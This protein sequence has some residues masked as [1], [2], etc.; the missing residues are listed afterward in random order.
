MLRGASLAHADVGAGRAAVPAADRVWTPVTD[1]PPL[2]VAASAGYGVTESQAGEG[3]HHRVEGTLAAAVGLTPNI[4]ASLGFEGRYDI[5][6]DGDSG[7][8]GTPQLGLVGGV[9]AADS[10]RIG[11]ALQL[12]VPG[13]SAPS[14]D[15]SALA[16][17]MCGLAAWDAGQHFT[18]AGL[19]GF[20]FDKSANAAADAERLSNADRLALGLSDFNAVPFGLAAFQRVA[21]I[22]LLAELSGE[23]LVGADAPDVLHSPL[24]AALGGRMPIL[25][26]LMAELLLELSLSQRSEYARIAPLIPQEPRFTIGLGLRYA[27]DFGAAKPPPPA[28]VVAPERTR[29]SGEISDPD[30][31][32]LAGVRVTVRVAGR[33][34]SVSSEDDGS[35]V[36]EDLP[37]GTAQIGI[38]GAGLLPS[39]Q[40]VALDRREVVLPLQVA[41]AAV[42]AQ[43]RGLVRSFTGAALP[44]RVRVLP[45][46]GAVTADKDGRFML[47]LQA[48]EYEVE[49]ECAGYLTQ[50]RKIS[51]QDNGVTLLNVELHE[52]PR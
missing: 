15:F 29:L 11:A 20:R 37:R 36:L 12:V 16:L 34:Y 49:I 51:V 25:P 18:L 9:H 14:L 1:A 10:V 42:S 35:F 38:E 13:R 33:E 5:H 21:S 50:H 22:E 24:R 28:P 17:S 7:A 41:R 26:T 3:A 46:A 48:G 6:P 40:P 27:P 45:D 44:A 47:E 30:G 2:S 31:V 32:R 4:A 43:L 52:V 23:V 39:T 8:V 19:L